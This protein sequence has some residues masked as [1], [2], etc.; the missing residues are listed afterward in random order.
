M[1]TVSARWDLKITA[2]APL[3]H[4]G[5]TAGTTA[6]L[7]RMKI[8]QPDGTFELVPVIFRKFAARSAAPHRRRAA[9]RRTL[10]I[11]RSAAAACG[12]PVAQRRIDRQ[13]DCGTSDRSAPARVSSLGPAGECVRGRDRFLPDQWVPAGWACPALDPGSSPGAAIRVQEEQLPSSFDVLAGGAGTCVPAAAR[14]ARASRP[15]DPVDT[16]IAV[17]RCESSRDRPTGR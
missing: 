3:S 14:R 2:R 1:S 11:R 8:V 10:K 6:L 17:N 12:A 13:V 5:D 9:A 15:G 4:R 7:R 16:S